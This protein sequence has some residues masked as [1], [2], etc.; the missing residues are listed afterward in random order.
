MP[1]VLTPIKD[2]PLIKGGEFLPDILQ[3]SLIN[4]K[5]KLRDGDILA[6]TQKIVSK[7]EKR[8]RYLDKVS[9]GEKAIEI[10][11][12][13]IKDPRLIEL[14]LRESKE[15]IRVSRSTLIVEHKLGF[16]C[17]NAGIDHSNVKGDKNHEK[18]C[19]LLLPEDPE[20]SA[21][22]IGEYIGNQSGVDI[23]VIIIDSHGRAWRYGTV[24]VII[25]T[26]RVPALLDLKG[27]KDLFNYQLRITRI[28]AADELAAAA[29]LIMG[30]ADEGIPA[31][32][33]R[34]FP[35]ELRDTT[36]K[37]LIRPKETDL[38]R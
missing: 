17:A 4:Q 5:I 28:S 2:I 13:N 18:C 16:I 15:V 6:V 21:K 3:K 19:Y 7:A 10:S 20:K 1:L 35:Y 27:R 25:G 36:I 26:Y 30:Q 14:I 11:R 33:I 24:G 29:S 23:G 38:F 8:T 32:H 31:V 22:S 34:G 12:I 9:P 37:E